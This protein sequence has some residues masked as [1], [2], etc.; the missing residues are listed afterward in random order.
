[1]Y[2]LGIGPESLPTTLRVDYIV[3]V[4]SSFFLPSGYIFRNY[5]VSICDGVWQVKTGKWKGLFFQDRGCPLRYSR[6]KN[7]SHDQ[8]QKDS[9]RT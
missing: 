7:F 8:I 5:P 1:M 2:I 6:Q 4:V 9:G 3:Y